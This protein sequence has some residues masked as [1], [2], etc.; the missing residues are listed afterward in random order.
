MAAPWTIYANQLVPKRN[1]HALWEPNPGA[2]PAVELADVGYLKDGAFI[3]LFNASK[4]LGDKSN[5][6]GVPEGYRRLNVGQ[7][8][9]REPLPERPNSIRSRSISIKG[10]ELNASGG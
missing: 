5:N 3:R 10:V 6:L 7:I 9:S 1:G 4:V 2:S 8:Q